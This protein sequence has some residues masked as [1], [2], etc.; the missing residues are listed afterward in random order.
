MKKA[1]QQGRRGFGAR[2]LHGVREGERREE[3]QV[4]E[5]E[6]RQSPDLPAR[7]LMQIDRIYSSEISDIFLTAYK[8]LNGIAR[9]FEK[10]WKY[11]LL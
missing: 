10:I 5:R 8:S 2:S 7:T 6:A 3:R 4:C 11:C 1:G 9:R